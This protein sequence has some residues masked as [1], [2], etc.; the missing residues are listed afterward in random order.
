MN[1][2]SKAN[3]YERLFTQIEHLCVAT[4]FPISRMATIS[5][6]LHHKLK[7]FF[8]TGFY[9]LQETELVVGPYQGSLACLKL[10]KNSG[11]CWAGINQEASVVVADVDKFPGH[12]ACSPLSKSEIV[13]PVFDSNNNVVGVLDIDSKELNAFDDLD[14]VGLEKIVSLIYKNFESN[15]SCSCTNS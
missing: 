10:K 9:L 13:I 12:I 5:A 7:G 15:T 3:R 4:S 14:R 8:W 11:V 1:T 2:E 6:I